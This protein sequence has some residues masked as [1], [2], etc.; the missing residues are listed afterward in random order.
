MYAAELTSKTRLD[1]VIF[2]EQNISVSATIKD[3]TPSIGSVA[4]GTRLR[5]T[6]N[7][8]FLGNNSTMPVVFVKVP[9]STTFVNGLVVC[10]VERY[11]FLLL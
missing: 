8:G 10:D 2:M 5:I 9:I 1:K 11:V 3:V 7:D 6:M 4:G